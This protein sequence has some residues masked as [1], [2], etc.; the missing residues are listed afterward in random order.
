MEIPLKNFHKIQNNT[1]VYKLV[2]T[3]AVA[4]KQFN[5]FLK[6]HPLYRSPMKEKLSLLSQ[7]VEH[8]EKRKTK[9]ISEQA[10]QSRNNIFYQVQKLDAQMPRLDALS[11]LLLIRDAIHMQLFQKHLLQSS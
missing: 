1:S 11:L 4:R 6:K 10:K 8:L 5:V 7:F 3:S 2:M 9:S